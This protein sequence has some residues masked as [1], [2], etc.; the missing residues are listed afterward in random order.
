MKTI[1]VV[2]T[3]VLLGLLTVS[4]ASRHPDSLQ[5]QIVAKEREELDALKTTDVRTFAALIADDAVF[6]DGR[7]S[8]GKA[9][10][11]S[12][13]TDFKVLE[14]SMDEIRFVPLSEHSGVI[15]YKLT[16]RASAHGHEFTATAYASAVWVERAG[17][18]LCVFSQETSARSQ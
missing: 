14:Y 2:A 18:W 12:H 15:A 8:A 16:Q 17:K 13:V 1:L 3:A 7:G 9:E 4:A 10:V 6:V 11:V 5:Q